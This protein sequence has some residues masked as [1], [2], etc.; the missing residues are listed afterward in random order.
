MS[1]SV[2]PP[3]IITIRASSIIRLLVQ[4]PGVS[5]PQPDGP[6]SISDAGYAANLYK[7]KD[8]NFERTFTTRNQLLFQTTEDLKVTFTYAYQQTKTDG[9]QS[10]N[11][12][13]LGTGNYEN[14]GRFTEP[15]DAPCASC[16]HGNQ[17]KYRRHRRSC[18]DHGLYQCENRVE[19]RQ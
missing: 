1:P 5:L 11:A 10:N 6:I 4:N 3:A 15:V 14:G 16:Q 12:G 8:L 13:V 7:L 18:C 2:R 19:R 9:S 17:R